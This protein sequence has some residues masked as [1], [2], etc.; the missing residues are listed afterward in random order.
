MEPTAW[1]DD[2]EA[3]L[4][5]IGCS[6]CANQGDDD[7]EF[8][9]RFLEGEFADVYLQRATPLP[10]YSV[11]VWK[12]G[13]V[14]EATALDDAAASGF[15]S[16]TLAAARALQT[17]FSPAKL[18]FLTL[19]NAVPHLHTHILPRYLGDPAPGRPLPWDLV[20][21][22]PALAEGDFRQ[23]VQGL[24]TIVGSPHH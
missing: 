21:T 20:S 17:Q 7:N 9:A 10:G 11:A 1:P 22:A 19:G 4:R 24:R 15:W 5:G 6:M 12:V 14:A 13:H 23:Q 16:E 3:R 8:G 18:N 2:W